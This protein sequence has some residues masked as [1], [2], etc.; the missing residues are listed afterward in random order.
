MQVC[1]IVNG[2]YSSLPLQLPHQLKLMVVYVLS[3]DLP[4]RNNHWLFPRD[5]ASANGASAGVG[6]NEVSAGDEFLKVVPRN[7][8]C[9]RAAARH[10]PRMTILYEDV[11]IEMTFAL[12]FLDSSYQTVKWLIRIADRDENQKIEPPYVPFG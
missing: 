3:E 10:Y 11:A 1:G 2:I 7:K 4:P 6:N 8:C 12:G 9:R 5:K